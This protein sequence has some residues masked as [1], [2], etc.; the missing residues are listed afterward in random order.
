MKIGELAKA[1]GTDTETLRYYERIGL[2]APPVRQAN[3]YRSYPEQ[4]VQQVRFIRHCRDLGISLAESEQILKLSQ[5][6]EADCDEINR[7]LAAHVTQVRAR[8]QALQTLEQQLL[9]LQGQ[10]GTSQR[11]ADCGILRDLV[12]AADEAHCACHG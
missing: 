11:T 9:A 12:A 2:L 6:P 4:A 7:I 1:T 10:C 3:G 8:M 5:Q